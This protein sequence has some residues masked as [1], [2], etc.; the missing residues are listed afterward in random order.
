MEILTLRFPLWSAEEAL[1]RARGL[2]EAGRT[3]A[4]FTPN[5]EMAQRA[6][7]GTGFSA[8]MAQADF[9]I[10]DGVGITLGAKMAGVRLPRLPGIDFAEQ[11][12]A[13]PPTG[14]GRWRVYLLG[15]RA[16]VARAAAA[17][18]EGRYP[19]KVVGVRDGYFPREEEAAVAAAVTAAAPH[20][21]LVCLGSPKQEEWIIRHRPPCLAL[22]LGGSLDIW[23]GE[24]QRAP[25]PLRRAGL[26][27]LWR[28]LADPRRWR[29]AL[30]LPAYFFSLLRSPPTV[31]L[32]NDVKGNKKR[33]KTG[34]I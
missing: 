27:W 1:L 12:M 3:A 24:K 16:G 13:M 26:E 34:E 32:Q 8:L 7:G 23:A 9:L 21:L 22:G 11:L 31:F 30:S 2:A 20:L 4:I 10:A 29:R 25:L 33:K 5:A 17:Y 15:G 28:L 18:L 6:A 19:V 14:D